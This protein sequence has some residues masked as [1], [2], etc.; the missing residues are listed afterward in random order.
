MLK[1]VLNKYVK[2]HDLIDFLKSLEKNS[3]KKIFSDTKKIVFG[4]NVMVKFYWKDFKP[5]FSFHS[6]FDVVFCN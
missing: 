3:N 1:A 4:E 2:E 5:L 6:F